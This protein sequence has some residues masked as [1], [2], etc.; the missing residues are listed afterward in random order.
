MQNLRRGMG[1]AA[2]GLDL[3]KP[4]RSK[5][6]AE[7]VAPPKP[8]A[9]VVETVDRRYD[10]RVISQRVLADIDSTAKDGFE[11]R[12]YLNDR[13]EFAILGDDSGFKD[14][15]PLEPFDEAKD[16][17][18]EAHH[19]EVVKIEVLTDDDYMTFS[20]YGDFLEW[21]ELD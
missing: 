20:S 16:K 1:K 21:L 11:V 3:K 19:G 8:P 9:G 17:I 18:I 5:L 13:R 2:K 4:M 10:L 15:Q 6:A 7:L 14:L 12:F